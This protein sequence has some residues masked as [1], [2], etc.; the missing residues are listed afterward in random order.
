MAA[1]ARTVTSCGVAHWARDSFGWEYAVSAS[2]ALGVA[3]MGLAAQWA[4]APSSGGVFVC[5]RVR[6]IRSVG[7]W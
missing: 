7:T 4:L 5:L 3:D 6:L 1:C 2:S